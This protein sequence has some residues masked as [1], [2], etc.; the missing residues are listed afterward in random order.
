[1][2]TFP[3]N[4]SIT[5]NLVITHEGYPP[6]NRDTSSKSARPISRKSGFQTTEVKEAFR[7]RRFEKAPIRILTT[8]SERIKDI[9]QTIKLSLQNWANNLVLAAPRHFLT[10]ISFV[11]VNA[12]AR[13]IL[14]KL[15]LAISM[16]NK[17]TVKMEY[18]CKALTAL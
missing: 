4:V 11:L 13:L 16:I 14:I 8:V 6:A 9:R 18:I 7:A 17:P 3:F 12:L 5:L 2:V 10:P 1:M 15:K